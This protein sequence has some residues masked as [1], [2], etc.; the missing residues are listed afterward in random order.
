MSL[1]CAELGRAAGKIAVM[2]PAVSSYHSVHPELR[3]VHPGVDPALHELGVV[4]GC[5]QHRD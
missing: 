3:A 5:V 4:S 2:G 1:L